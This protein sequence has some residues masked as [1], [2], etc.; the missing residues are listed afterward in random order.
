MARKPSPTLTD[1]ET[2]LMKVLWAKGPSTVSDIVAALPR[3]Q[4]VAYNTVQTLMRILET[5]GYVTHE[6]TG[7][8]FLYRAL[9]DQP[10]ARKRAI[11]HLMKALFDN[12]PRL[13]LLNL[14]D[15]EQ[16]DPDQ[17]ERLKRFIEEA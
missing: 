4:A 7:R 12:S 6:Q 3:R 17:A 15:D 16:L 14:L 11:G 9:V 2:R 1:G 8:A 13:L 5:K 10:T